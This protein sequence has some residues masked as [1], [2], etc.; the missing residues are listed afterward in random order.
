MS[1]LAPSVPAQRGLLAKIRHR[2]SKGHPLWGYLYG[3]WLRRRFARSGLI[4]VERGLPLP[5]VKNEQGTLECENILLY[6]GVRLW[7]HKG[8]GLSIGNGTYL[9]RGAEVIAWDN[10]TIGR[11]CMI[12]WDVVI[13]DT[14]LHPVGD[15][16]LRNKPVT[17]GDRVWIGCRA[18]ILKGVT[19]GEG[20][21]VSA[22]AIVHRDVPPYT[23]VSGDPARVVGQVDAEHQP[24]P[25]DQ[26]QAA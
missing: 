21:I 22:G 8:G 4:A 12:G 18:I 14:D 15:R 3:F 13:L 26:E 2:L 25:G 11:D 5:Q 20:A 16:P 23:I 1:E 7:A 9:N 24:T 17:I 19:I 10:V 6:P